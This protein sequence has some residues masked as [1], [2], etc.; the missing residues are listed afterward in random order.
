M[1]TKGKLK[2]GNKH[3]VNMSIAKNLTLSPDF[4]ET[5]N[6]YKDNLHYEIEQLTWWLNM[7]SVELEGYQRCLKQAQRHLQRLVK[8]VEHVH[9]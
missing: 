5:E 6:F 2:M 1:N 3:K 9:A 4:Q 8:E 7:A